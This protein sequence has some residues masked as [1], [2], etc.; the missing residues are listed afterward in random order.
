MCL[1]MKSD[2]RGWLIDVVRIPKRFEKLKSDMWFVMYP[3]NREQYVQ[4]KILK[5]FW[6]HY[7][8]KT[9]YFITF[10]DKIHIEE[11]FFECLV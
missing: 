1:I 5:L 9:P 7:N 6:N 8:I 4:I 10:Y 2:T 11:F 3:I